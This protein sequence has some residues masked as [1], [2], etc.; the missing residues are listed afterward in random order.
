M[1]KY[2]QEQLKRMAIEVIEAE[3]Q[4]DDRAFELIMAMAL[5]LGMTP[6]DVMTRIDQLAAA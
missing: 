2:S 5:K 1:A 6:N 4:G 3:S